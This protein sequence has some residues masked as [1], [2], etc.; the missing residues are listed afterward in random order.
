MIL[1]IDANIVIAAL[2]KNSKAREIIVDGRFRFVAPDFIK[3]EIYKHS[4]YVM[5]KAHLNHYELDILIAL[6]FETINIIPRSDYNSEMAKARKIMQEDLKDA[7]YAACY[8]ALKCDG[9]WT[10]DSHFSDKPGL[11][12]VKTD[13]LLKLM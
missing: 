5:Q 13:Y 6:I 9:I 12:T 2:I 7:Q 1:V 8:F 11:N 10:N 4:S 3:D